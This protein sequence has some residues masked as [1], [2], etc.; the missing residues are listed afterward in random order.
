MFGTFI[1]YM[2]ITP[3]D[4]DDLIKHNHKINKEK[5]ENVNLNDF[6]TQLK[7]YYFRFKT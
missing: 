1:D 2:N 3:D 7:G 6:K 5:S 4:F